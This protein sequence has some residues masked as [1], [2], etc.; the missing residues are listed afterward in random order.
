MRAIG[1]IG[2]LLGVSLLT[3]CHGVART[4]DEREN[5]ARQSADMDARQLADDHD[6]IWMVDRQYR[7]TRWQTR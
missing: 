5:K 4:A 1:L 7:L 2:L 6:R 3:G